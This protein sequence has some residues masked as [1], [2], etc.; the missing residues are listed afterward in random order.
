MWLY[1][2]YL[3]VSVFGLRPSNT[4]SSGG[5]SLMCPT[6]YAMKL[7][8]IDRIIRTEG[9]APTRVLF[10][11]IRDLEMFLR[12]PEVVAVN[13]TFQKIQRPAGGKEEVWNSTIAQREFCF[14]M[15]EMTIAMAVQEDSLQTATLRHAFTAI[16]YFGRRGGFFQWDGDVLEIDPPHENNG[17]VNLSA[18]DAPGTLSVGFLQRMDDIVPEATFDD[19]SIWNPKA[20]GGRRSYTVILPYELAR[21]GAGHTVYRRNRG[22]L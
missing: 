7:A 18:S 2:K 4:T 9:E 17:F 5:K 22:A 15:G 19:I 14:H 3:P 8:L 1:V 20:K 6:P 13:R 12:V 16:N 10:P 21:H 11:L